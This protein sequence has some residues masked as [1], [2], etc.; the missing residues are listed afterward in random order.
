[1]GGRRRAPTG[2]TCGDV[3][4]KPGDS[5]RAEKSRGLRCVRSSELRPRARQPCSALGGA[6]LFGGGECCTRGWVSGGRE[7]GEPPAH[8]KAD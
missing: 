1:M 6:R 3:K 8:V 2:E 4:G 7:G 5:R